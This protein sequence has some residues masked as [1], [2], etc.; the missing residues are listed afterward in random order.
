MTPERAKE[1]LPIIRAY[2]EGA[3]IE[4]RAVDTNNPWRSYP[5]KRLA[6]LDDVEYRIKPKTPEYRLYQ[7]DT[8]LIVC[9]QRNAK[10]ENTVP[11]IMQGY[12]AGI[13]GKWITDWLPIPNQPE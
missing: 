3:T 1:L 4:I 12:D 8:G 11:Y 13:R 7:Y 2:S 6:W 9:A 10:S 5:Y